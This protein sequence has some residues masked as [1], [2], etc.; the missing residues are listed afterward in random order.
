M[1]ITFPVDEKIKARLDSVC[2]SLEVTYEEWFETALIDS[3]LYV[4]CMLLI[5]SPEEQLDWE[6]DAGLCRFVRSNGA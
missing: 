5:S 3:E 2:K 1:Y 6:W 4:L